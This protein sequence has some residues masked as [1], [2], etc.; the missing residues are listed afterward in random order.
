[1]STRRQR[2]DAAQAEIIA[3]YQADIRLLAGD[4][5]ESIR[6]REDCEARNAQLV[7]EL[8]ERAAAGR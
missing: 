6:R 7:T 4:L 8:A 3:S 1:V 2:W 5:A